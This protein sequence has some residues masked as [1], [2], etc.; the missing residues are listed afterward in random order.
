LTNLQVLI[1]HLPLEVT[2][3]LSFMSNESISDGDSIMV[4]VVVAVIGRIF[5]VVGR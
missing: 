4:G 2:H 1:N 3:E 5:V